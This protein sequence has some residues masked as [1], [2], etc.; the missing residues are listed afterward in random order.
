MT[1]HNGTNLFVQALILLQHVIDVL[2]P[3]HC[4]PILTQHLKTLMHRSNSTS[5]FRAVEPLTQCHCG[6][7]SIHHRK[8]SVRYALAFDGVIVLVTYLCGIAV[9]WLVWTVHVTSCYCYW[10][11][12]VLEQYAV[13]DM[14]AGTCLE[15][16][17][18]CH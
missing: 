15:Y 11:L 9:N 6:L 2:K 5:N 13:E 10:T 14:E 4:L 12:R 16:V 18:R 7:G 3:L 17:T 1:S 8:L